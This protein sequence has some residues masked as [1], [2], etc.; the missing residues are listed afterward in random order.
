LATST[1]T[2]Q[3]HERRREPR[4][5]KHASLLSQTVEMPS[6]SAAKDTRGH[7]LFR[8]FGGRWVWRLFIGRMTSAGRW[9]LIPTVFLFAYASTSLTMQA[10]IPFCYVSALWA[11]A[12]IAPL[13]FKPRVKLTVQHAQH[14]VAG[15]IMP[16]EVEIEQLGWIGGHDL[17][18]LPQQLPASIDAVE[19]DGV[20]LPVLKKG[21]RVRVVLRL[22]CSHRGAFSMNGFR[23]ETD[24]PFGMW[25]S[26][27]VFE[28]QRR[29]I[30]YPR[31]EPLERIDLPSSRRYQPGGVALA[32]TIGESV[33]FVGN[34]EYRAGD[35]IR[36]I[37]WR[38][39]ARL[40]KP[41]VREY[42]E[43]YLLRVAVVLDTQLPKFPSDVERQAFESA[44][45]VCASVSDWLARKEYVVDILAAG[46]DLYHL[47]AGRHLAFIDQIL[48]ILACVDSGPNDGFDRIEPELGQNLAS[49]GAVICVFLDWDAARQKFAH[50]IRDLGAAM[51]IIIVRNAPCTLDPF[52]D[53]ARLGSVHVVTS[54][55]VTRGID[56]I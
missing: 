56:V 2:P 18:V 47:Q 35:N 6:F 16:V 21:E 23:A 3:R 17:H 42:R 20:P 54:E 7:S 1:P 4:A 5:K 32:A 38:A 8:S 25:R 13:F 52:T 11:L 53:E 14:V 48:D 43:E 29:L 34:R 10:Y 12:L 46:P 39:S 51:K 37:D 9:M 27:R 19:T 40:N 41:I 49:I 15:E 45:S 33:E 24:F 36:D 55:E 44:I 30:V 22:I 26:Y 31:F 50:T 28:R